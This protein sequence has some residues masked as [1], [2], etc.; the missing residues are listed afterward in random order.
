MAG[1]AETQQQ[2]KTTH[3]QN[4]VKIWILVMLLVVLNII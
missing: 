1:T 4:D 2:G 3:N